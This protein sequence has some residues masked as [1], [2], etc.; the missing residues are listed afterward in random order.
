M[1]SAA[2]GL[3]AGFVEMQISD[4]AVSTSDA[5]SFAAWKDTAHFRGRLTV[6]VLTWEQIS[7]RWGGFAFVSI[8]AEGLSAELF[9]RMLALDLQPKC[10]AVEHDNRLVQ[11]AEAATARH[12]VCT[13]ANP[14]NAVFVRNG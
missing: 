4:D 2:R 1:I 14:T 6:P 9:L 5:A 10:V 8:D 7:T 13:Y 12:Y 11:L 3:E